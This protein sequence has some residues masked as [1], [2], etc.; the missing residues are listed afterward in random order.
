MKS[1]RLLLTLLALALLAL[2]IVFGVIYLRLQQPRPRG[3]A[4]QRA[5]ALARS[6][7]IA[8]GA[9]HLSSVAALRFHFGPADRRHLYDL[10]RRLAEVRYQDAEQP[11]RVQF[12]LRDLHGRAWRAGRRL[13]N[14]EDIR[15]AVRAA[16]RAFTNDYFWLLPFTQ[17]RAPGAQREFIGQR[18]LAIHYPSGGVTPGDS[19]LIVTDEKGLP[20]RWQMW[21]SAIRAPGMEFR[22]SQWRTVH[23]LRF[24]TSYEGAGR[25]VQLDE[26]EIFDRFPAV[27]QVDP[28]ESLLSEKGVTRLWTTGRLA[29]GASSTQN[30]D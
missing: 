21:V 2:A 13:E 23:G 18:A 20:Q 22:L 17:L 6:I 26:I 29:D 27:G 3:A 19:Y 5:E 14:T 4:D 15:T 9:D 11:M 8:T 12:S 28:F 16:Y 1:H 30:Q 25:Q 10:H 7:E 24:C